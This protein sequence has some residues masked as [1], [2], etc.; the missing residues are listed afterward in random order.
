MRERV[1][2]VEERAELLGLRERAVLLDERAHLGAVGLGL[3]RELDRVR[4]DDALVGQARDVGLDGAG[5]PEHRRQRDRALEDDV[6]VVLPREADPAVQL[7]VLLR[8]HHE[9]GQRLRRGD[10]DREL[11]LGSARLGAR[12]VPR[13]RGGELG[14]DEHV[15]GLVLDR[16]EHPDDAPELL[17]HLG[18]L[19][20][21][22]HARRGTARRLGGGEEAT[23]HDRGAARAG[24]DAVGGR[25]GGE[26]HRA[27][28]SGRVGVRRHRDRD[29]VAGGDHEV[30][31]AREEE[32]VGEPGA[33]H[34]VGGVVEPDRGAGRAVGQPR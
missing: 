18:V 23:E 28:A 30:V 24:E 9:R 29:L 17:A 12:R 32:Q 21:H 13:G 15:G 11:E 2:G 14:R 27:E 19:A 25:V 7:D 34:E 22:G 31:A 6:G 16:L 26:R 3:G 20:R 1:P 10:G 4:A 33:E 8:A 5:G